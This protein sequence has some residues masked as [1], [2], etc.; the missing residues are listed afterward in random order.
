MYRLIYKFIL[1][2]LLSLK[3]W[4]TLFFWV[5]FIL[6]SNFFS[7]CDS[8]LEC[9]QNKSKDAEDWTPLKNEKIKFL[10]TLGRNLIEFELKE[11]TIDGNKQDC[12]GNYTARFTFLQDSLN[13]LYIRSFS[14]YLIATDKEAIFSYHF[15]PSTPLQTG[16]LNPKIQEIG[17]VSLTNNL[18]CTSQNNQQNAQGNFVD[19][20]NINGILHQNVI[21]LKV[22]EIISSNK[23]VKSI[24]VNQKG[25]LRIEFQNDEVWNRI[26]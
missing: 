11:I 9:N 6:L 25:I 22:R 21:E 13:N 23:S 2:C 12:N 8:F 17:C 16:V 18:P 1:S 10:P 19:A 20:I 15:L 5:Y 26:F 24:L 4:K 3:K 14:Y 7:S